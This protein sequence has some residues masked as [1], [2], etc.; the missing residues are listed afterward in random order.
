MSATTSVTTAAASGTTGTGGQRQANAA[1]TGLGTDFNTF[2]TLLTTQLR[3]QDPTNAM[4][5]N[6][7][8]EQLVQFTAVEQQVQTNTS[9][10]QLI[11]LQQGNT[12]TSAADL[13]GRVVEV[14]SSQ[15]ALQNSQAALRLPAAGAARSALIQISDSTGRVVR[16]ARPTLT[17]GSTSTWN[18]DGRD[19][20][21]RLL[22]DGSYGFTIQGGDA[23]GGAVSL[24]A[25]VLARPT[26]V[27]RA[28]GSVQLRFGSLSLGYDKLRS[29]QP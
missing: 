15:M 6:K 27:E 8:T 29:V 21:G 20:A 2:L 24:T 17:G 3:N 1:V 28:N 9:L 25:G 22:A 26:G 5:V 10:Q 23:N 7:M 14:E 13:L 11:A 18:W 16:E 19:S 4:D 12:L